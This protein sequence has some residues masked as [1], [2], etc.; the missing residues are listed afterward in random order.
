MIR[1]PDRPVPRP[2]LPRPPKPLLR[3][4]R[5]LPPRPILPKT[6]PAAAAPAGS[7]PASA[8]PASGSAPRP[9]KVELY[10]PI[11]PFAIDPILTREEASA[12]DADAEAAQ[13]RAAALELAGDERTE[14]LVARLAERPEVAEVGLA[15]ADPAEDE[16]KPA[17]GEAVVRGFGE[18]SPQRAAQAERAVETVRTLADPAR[19][20]ALSLTA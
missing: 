10:A 3:P 17:R 20:P 8:P 6:A 2:R 13:A 14:A 11:V 9:S 5:P 18:P 19:A 1:M 16:A 4:S 12:P 15:A 7:A